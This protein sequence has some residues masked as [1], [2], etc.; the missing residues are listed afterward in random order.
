MKTTTL[1]RLYLAAG[2][3]EEPLFWGPI[4]L[5]AMAKL[6]HMSTA[7]I[8]LSEALASGLVLVLDA[9]SGILADMLGRKKCVVLGK[10]CLLAS[11]LFLAFMESPLHCYTANVLW[12]FGVSLR[13]GAD[14]ALIY[15]ELQKRRALSEYQSLMKKKHSYRFFIV[16]CTTLA[17]GFIAEIDLRLPLLISLPGVIISSLLMLLFP[18]DG[19]HTREHSLRSYKRHLVEAIC[20]VSNK[21]RLGLLLIWFALLAMVSKIYFFTYNPY[22]ELVAVPYWQVGIIFCGIN[23]FGFVASRYAFQIQEKLGRVGFGIC[24]WLQGAVMLF[25]AGYTY[26]LSGWLFVIA[27]GIRWGYINTITEPIL[28]KEIASERRATILS[29]HS[30]L[31]SLLHMLGFLVTSMIAGSV[32]TLLAALGVVSVLLGILSRKV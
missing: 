17:T 27:G 8:F 6:G 13:S 18:T 26:Y 10:T 24:F 20:E 32:T 3:L 16:A 5:V 30:S 29:F 28:N 23:L 12:A 4:L 22:L 25:Q 15:D 1:V 7:D 9:P 2:L 14:S 31:C 19:T 21:K 11:V